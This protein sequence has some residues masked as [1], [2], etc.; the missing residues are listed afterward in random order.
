MA[1]AARA[2]MTRRCFN[3][4]PIMNEA[5]IVEPHS[6]MYNIWR[7]VES[8][9]NCVNAT[10]AAALIRLRP[11]VIPHYRPWR[12]RSQSLTGLT[13]PATPLNWNESAIMLHPL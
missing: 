2:H 7:K 11:T 1:A 3:K 9:R 10:P 13:R 4:G 8:P 6:I 12:A 5:L